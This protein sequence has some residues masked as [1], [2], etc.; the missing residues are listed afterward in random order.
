MHFTSMVSSPIW[1]Q[2]MFDESVTRPQLQTWKSLTPRKGK[3]SPFLSPVRAKPEIGEL[4]KW[5]IR[6]LNL[7]F[8]MLSGASIWLEC[9]S[10]G[11]G[12][13]TQ[14][15]HG[16]KF[17]L[18]SMG[19]KYILVCFRKAVLSEC[20]L[21]GFKGLFRLSLITLRSEDLGRSSA[22]SLGGVVILE[23]RQEVW[24]LRMPFHPYLEL[25]FSI[26]F[27]TYK[28]AND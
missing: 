1:F 4:R 13:P 11:L 16:A 22:T 18:T 8:S 5:K 10:W 9:W 15:I 25:N 21:D 26:T 19:G 17:Q 27:P 12:C 2:T 28:I 20:T 6:S 7:T 23:G 24:P 3:T 14:F